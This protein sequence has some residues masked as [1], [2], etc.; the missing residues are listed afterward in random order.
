MDARVHNFVREIKSDLHYDLRSNTRGVTQIFFRSRETHH[1]GAMRWR[2]IGSLRR[3]LT[4]SEEPITKA[5]LT[6]N[7]R[8]VVKSVTFSE[9]RR[10]CFRR[11][12]DKSRA[13]TLEGDPEGVERRVDQRF[14]RVFEAHW[15]LACGR[16]V[17]HA[18]SSLRLEPLGHE[19]VR[20]AESI[21]IWNCAHNHVAQL[22]IELV[23][24]IAE[25]SYVP[26]MLPDVRIQVD[27][28]D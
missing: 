21:R 15:N 22:L 19:N 18:S 25:V 2:T 16:C 10:A 6:I 23:G 4:P 28:T 7:P 13:L 1:S 14:L 11:H 12:R 3:F 17:G 27:S 26:N 5:I 9:P 20:L 24:M 8:D